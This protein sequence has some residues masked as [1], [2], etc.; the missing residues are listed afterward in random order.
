MVDI[1]RYPDMIA[2]GV[3]R[4]FLYLF[5][6]TL[7][8]GTL[9]SVIIGYQLNRSIGNF[10]TDLSNNMP[11]F[12]FQNGELDVKGKMPIIL[13]GSK[14]E[15]T[16][17]DTTGKTTEDALNQYESAMLILKDR[18]IV[19]RNSAETRIISFNE[20]Q[21]VAFTKQ[22]V[23][24][25]LPH[26]KW[27]APIIAVVAWIA[28][29]IGKM[30]S[31]LFLAIINSIISSI[32]KIRLSFGR[33][34]SLS[35]YSLSLPMILDIIFKLFHLKLS[36]FIYFVIALVYAWLAMGYMKKEAEPIEE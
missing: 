28:F 20:F 33:L 5:L 19:K 1:R 14:D 32:R 21:D 13:R 30:V 17:I 11:D 23:V 12:T 36:G 16:I 24:N 26:L 18:M 35:I 4:A 31:A 34:Y 29:F 27:L 22:D 7:L 9:N 3:G 15:V 25:F 6:F 10:T 2:Q 8:F